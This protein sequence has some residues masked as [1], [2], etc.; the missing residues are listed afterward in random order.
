MQW[1]EL[2]Y[3]TVRMRGF[4]CRAGVRLGVDRFDVIGREGTPL[5]GMHLS[6]K[7]G[8]GALVL[9]IESACQTWFVA[10]NLERF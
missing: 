5:H 6:I 8:P 9:Q 7:Y 1:G 3:V 2:L 10:R 4:T